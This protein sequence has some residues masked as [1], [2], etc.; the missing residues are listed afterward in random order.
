MSLARVLAIWIFTYVGSS[1]EAQELEP[2]SGQTLPGLKHGLCQSPIN[3]LTRAVTKGSR[4]SIVLDYK[5]SSE[6][7]RNLGHTIEVEYDEGNTLAFDGRVF[8]FKQFHFHTPSEHLVDGVTY[9]MEMHMVHTL[10]ERNAD[11]ET[12]YLVVGALFKQGR[13]NPFLDEFIGA[14]PKKEGKEAIVQ[15]GVVDINDLFEL[16]PTLDYYHY[17]GSLTTPPYTETVTW[18]IIQSI[19]EASPEQIETFKQLEGSNARHV[20][21]LYGRQ[22]DGE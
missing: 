18:L 20:Q 15:G 4:H 13:E 8:E 6:H 11:N 16:A 17:D 2:R 9:P 19:F 12:I 7:V 3:I 22:V 5:R 14:I 10:G 1:L 21:A